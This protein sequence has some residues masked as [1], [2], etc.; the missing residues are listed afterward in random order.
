M[1]GMVWQFFYKARVVGHVE[2]KDVAFA[3]WCVLYLC[4]VK[5][6]YD[7]QCLLIDLLLWCI[8]SGKI[9]PVHTWQVEIS[10]DN[11]I[12]VIRVGAKLLDR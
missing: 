7:D 12:T 5:V 4:K 2:I 9:F 6:I 10:S 1:Y 3:G 8:F 11:E